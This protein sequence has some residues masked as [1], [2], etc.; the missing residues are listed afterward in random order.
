MR[1]K[2][3]CRLNV[4]LIQFPRTDYSPDFTNFK[5]LLI[6]PLGYLLDLKLF[7]RFLNSFLFFIMM[8]LRKE[9]G[10]EKRGGDMNEKSIES[11]ECSI[12]ENGQLSFSSEGSASIRKI[13]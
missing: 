1:D 10:A 11:H 12:P 6:K 5:N 13:V 4:F 7:L 8:R 9:N 2:R 3:W